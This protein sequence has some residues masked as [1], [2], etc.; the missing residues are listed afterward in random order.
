[1]T[2]LLAGFGLLLLWWLWRNALRRAPAAQGRLILRIGGYATL[3]VAGLVLIRGRP[4]L[5]VILAA[6]GLWCLEGE[7]G[8][9]RRWRAL[10][11]RVRVRARLQTNFHRRAPGGRVDADADADPRPRRP[12][13]PGAMTQEQAYEILG[14]ERGASLESIRAAHRG[15]MKRFHPDQ[16]GTAEQA[17]RVNAARD[18]LT[19]RHR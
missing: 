1:M 8:L 16:G 11:D 10:V 12:A 3:A 14:L 17:A 2:L 9:R 6:A 13:D 4:E 18:R 15:L 7:T 5:G 19:N